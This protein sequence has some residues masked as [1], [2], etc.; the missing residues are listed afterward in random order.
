MYLSDT[1]YAEGEGGGAC[2]FSGLQL[3]VLN[4]IRFIG[5]L[6]THAVQCIDCKWGV[7]G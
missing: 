2:G 1:Q 4:E 7:L 5:K 3:Y 6:C